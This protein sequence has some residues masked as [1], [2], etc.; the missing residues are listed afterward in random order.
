MTDVLTL[1]PE[2][3]PE[4]GLSQIQRVVNIFV[5]PSKTFEDLKR[6]RNW[7]VPFLLTIVFSTCFSYVLQ[8]KVGF[9]AMNQQ[10]IASS[11]AQ[12]ER[13][14]SLT[15]EQ[16][17]SQL[18][19]GA[20][21]SA[22]ISYAYPVFILLTAL[23]CSLVL[24]ASFNFIL[25]AQ[26]KFGEVLSVW[27]WA[28][29]TGLVAVIIMVITVYATGGDNFNIVDPI[30]TNPGYYLSADA[31]HWL[32]SLLTSIDLIKIWFCYLLILGVSIVGKVK[33]SAAAAVIIGWWV[34]VVLISVLAT[35]LM[36]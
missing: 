29:L 20:T 35:A 27:M 8:T 11:P 6:S 32:R 18:K 21:I 30:G 19:V 17:D 1:E 26:M 36:G 13:L 12:Q 22:V 10:R 16:R 31:P 24:W 5:A 9:Y 23:I 34:L 2:P 4:A 28:G 3:T 14:D 7:L 15:A 25:G 33:K